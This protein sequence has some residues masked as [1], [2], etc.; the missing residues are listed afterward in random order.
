MP[1]GHF[2]LTGL[3]QEPGSPLGFIDP[4]FDEAGGGDVAMLVADVVGLAQPRRQHLVVLA[5]LGEHVLRIDVVGVVV[6][7]ALEVADLADRFDRGTADLADALGDGI[8]HGE[9]AHPVRRTS[10]DSRG[11]AGRSGASGSSWSSG[12]ARTRPPGWRSWR[13]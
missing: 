10:S 1:A 6:Q 5:Q 4:D 11:S 8:G 9:F 12:R 13:R 7:D 3:K 2:A